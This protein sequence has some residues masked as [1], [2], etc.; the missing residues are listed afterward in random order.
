[1]GKIFEGVFKATAYPI[2]MLVFKTKF[3]YED[4]KQQNRKI[5]GSAK[6]V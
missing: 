4:K 2:E 3:H 6:N 5:K 1:M